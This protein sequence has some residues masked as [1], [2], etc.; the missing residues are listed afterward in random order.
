L[1]EEPLSGEPN[2]VVV[3]ERGEGRREGRAVVVMGRKQRKR[4]KERRGRFLHR[5]D[6]GKNWLLS[7][8]E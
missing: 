6:K 3:V 4:E 7:R 1:T 2:D 8:P 5:L